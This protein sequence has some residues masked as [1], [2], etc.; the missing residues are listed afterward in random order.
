MRERG[1]L[2]KRMEVQYKEKWNKNKHMI[3]TM[4]CSISFCI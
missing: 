3:C 4:G 1:K 2:S